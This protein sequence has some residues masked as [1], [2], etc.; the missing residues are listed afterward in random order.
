VRLEERRLLKLALVG[1]GVIAFIPVLYLTFLLVWGSSLTPRPTPSPTT[2]PPLVSQALWARAGGG[3]A[4]ELRGVN[5]INVAGLIVCSNLNGGSDNAQSLDAESLAECAKWLPALH[6]LEYLSSLHGQDHQI[7][8]A[9]FRGG[10]SSMATMLRLTYSWTR[11]EFLNTLAAQ[12]DF[13]Y[14]WKGIE[15]ASRGF[16]GRSAIVL[17]LAQSAFLASRVGDTR[18]DPW[19]EPAAATEMRNRVLDRMRI[20]GAVSA[21]DS[22]A[23]SV[24]ELDLAPPPEGRPPCRH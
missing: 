12:A 9:S 20:N 24:A 2:A 6:G 5:P 10:A 11:E 1:G 15:A 3:R 4:T 18:T 21:A 13:G 14:G 22:E 7:K 8:R 16:F 17:T 19:C 23:A